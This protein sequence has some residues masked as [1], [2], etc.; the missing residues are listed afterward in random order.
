MPINYQQKKNTNTTFGGTDAITVPVGSQAQ[1]SGTEIGQLRYNTDVGLPEFYTA[2]G[3]SAVAPPPTITTISGVI[4]ENTNST[5]TING[6]NFV[7][8]SVVSIEGAAVGGTPRTLTTTFVNSAQLTAATNAGSV[9]FV[10]GASFDLKVTN[11]SGLTASL[12]TAGN[13]DRD[14]AWATSVGNLGTNQERPIPGADIT[15]FTSGSDTFR[16][17]AFRAGGG[18]WTPN[19][20]G[21][22]DV[23]VVGGG[24]GG[25]YQ[26]GGGGGAGGLIYRSGLSVTSGSGINWYV[27]E[28][29]RGGG[30]AGQGEPNNGPDNLVATGGQDS[31]FGSLTAKGGGAGSNHNTGARSGPIGPYDG[32]GQAGGSGGGGAGDSASRSRA[33][34]TGN[35]SSQGGESGSFGFGNNGGQG[36]ASSWAGGGGGGAGGAGSNATSNTG[37]PGGVGRDYSAQFGTTY[38]Q[39]GF[40][41]GGGGG[42]SSGESGTAAVAGGNGG[43]GRGFA[44]N[45]Q[46][47][48]GGTTGGD[49]TVNTGGGG[50]GVRDRYDGSNAYIRAGN[51]GSGIILVR[52]N[53]NLETVPTR[54]TLSATDPDGGATTYSLAS[55][56]LPTGYTLNSSTGVISG[57]P[58]A[59]ASDTTYTF[60]VDAT[61][62]G[63]TV[64]RSFN[65]IISR[66][67]DGSKSDRAAASAA[68]IKSLT[69]TTIN[70]IYWIL[71]NGVA[72]PVYCDMNRDS[73][74]WM[75]A[76]N[77]NTS[78][79]SIVHYTNH[80]FWESPTK[81][82]SYPSGGGTV[83]N[84]PS[85]NV[86]DCFI[87]DYKAIEFGNL[88]NNFAG[89][90]FMVMVHNN[91]SYVGY[92][93]WNLNTAVATKFSE[94]WNG[95]RTPGNPG[96]G[97]VR[98][99]KKITNG[100][101]NSDIGSI[102][103]RTPNSYESQDL[104]TNA[105]NGES[106]LNRLTQVNSGAPSGPNT[107]HTYSR[108]DNAGAGFGTL[109]DRTAGGRPESDAQNWDSGT[110]TNSGGGRYGSDTLT[111][112]NFSSWGGKAYTTSG[113]GTGDTY[114]WNGYTGLDYDFAMFI[115]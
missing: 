55:G 96:S 35:Q 48:G 46:A 84:R 114:N 71:V 18:T 51:G 57:Y 44:N 63:Q 38:G 79:N 97:S 6:T 81:L 75:L 105:E 85:S 12:L 69:G 9:N 59:V 56:S 70:G 108:G 2:S 100:T 41:A 52:Y 110:W 17:L 39:S 95:P 92:R 78:D 64:N 42:C 80:D 15:S 90:K 22:V 54:F 107:N 24:G 1:R 74:G 82:T 16:I 72:T 73:G 10:G 43:G 65:I 31:Y 109:Y 14:P 20:T 87:R 66:T 91:G 27:G 77:I 7:S 19:F 23:L 111:N 3:W 61:S 26:V 58:P 113:A 103:S 101:T 60:G 83:S 102:N 112:D 93:S 62:A 21:T 5:I 30:W 115:K 99:Y 45:G 94:F 28:G 98:Y 13:I 86:N 50:G 88:W 53:V 47:L 36:L 67:N 25:G 37:G 106:D 76:M 40:F 33:G 29:G 34:G 68:A 49:G 11:P 8:G 104:I 89:T 32:L 4:N